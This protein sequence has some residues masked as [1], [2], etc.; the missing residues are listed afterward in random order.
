MRTTC[1]EDAERAK[2]VM[3]AILGP[4]AVEEV[5]E[6]LDALHVARA[7]NASLTL[8]QKVA[9]EGGKKLGD[10]LASLVESSVTGG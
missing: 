3:R 1:E 8:P 10:F 5:R 7:L 6:L 2:A 9:A 4:T